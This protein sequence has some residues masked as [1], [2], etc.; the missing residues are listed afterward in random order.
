MTS[1]AQPSAHR[2]SLPSYWVDVDAAQHSPAPTR[3]WQKQ[4]HAI[5]GALFSEDGSAPPAER[6]NWC[7]TQIAD[8]LE[9]VGG[10]G[11][12]AYRFAL[13][14]MGYF[15]PLLLFRFRSFA[16][17]PQA[18]RVRTLERVEQ[19]ALKTLLFALKALLCIVYFEHPDAA[20]ATGFDGLGLLETRDAPTQ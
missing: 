5:A 4:L 11:A 13:F 2:T 3:A 6:L 12:F 16:S 19:S 17:L 14:V 20:E 15:S 8:I 10:R 18:D 7:V 9:K 1:S